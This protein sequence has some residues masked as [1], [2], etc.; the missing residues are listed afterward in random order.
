MN[1]LLDL[2]PCS[3]P[4]WASPPPEVDWA[5]LRQITRGPALIFWPRGAPL[6]KGLDARPLYEIDPGDVA[7]RGN[8]RP[9]M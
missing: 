9:G 6:P 4:T 2:I 3:K 1:D 8:A 5:A 7:G